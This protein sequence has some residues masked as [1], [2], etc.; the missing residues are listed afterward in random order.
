[1]YFGWPHAHDDA[2]ERAVRGGLAILE[3]LAALNRRLA[4]DSVPPLAARIGID[5]GLVVVGEGGGADVEVFGET[6]NVAARV[7][8]L[9]HPD[10]ILITAA[11]HRLVAGLFVV[12]ELGAQQLKGLSAPVTVF[13]VRRP[14]GA[15]RRLDVAATSGLTPFVGREAER[16]LLD[17]RWQRTRGGEGQ[18]LLVTG[19]AGIGKSRLVQVLRAALAAEPHTWIECFGS[20]YHQN[21]PFFPVIDMLQ[22]GL[23][24]RGD[25]SKAVT[26]IDARIQNAFAKGEG[27]A[28]R[29]ARSCL[30]VARH[31]VS[32]RLGLSPVRRRI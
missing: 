31:S 19:E 4:A 24:W 5:T 11:T 10:S 14:S 7:Q 16:D 3:A 32:P 27:R 20:P 21:T 26:P 15:R 1:V 9:A 12:E 18:V 22:Q 25:E 13:R 6:P 23:A 17:Q 29:T 8:A 2:A 28:R 30:A